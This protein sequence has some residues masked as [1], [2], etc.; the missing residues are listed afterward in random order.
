M[1]FEHNTARS[2]PIPR[3]RYCIQKWPAN[4]AGLKRRG[5]LTLWLD[6]ASEER[7]LNG[8]E[9]RGAVVT[10]DGR[11]DSFRAADMSKL[12]LGQP[13][14]DASTLSKNRDGLLE[15]DVAP[16]FLAAWW[17]SPGSRR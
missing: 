10:G 14:W 8:R 16:A 1:P 17:S 9:G 13:V 3:A 11:N 5:D 2:H 4:E 15:G 7:G 6:E 12:T